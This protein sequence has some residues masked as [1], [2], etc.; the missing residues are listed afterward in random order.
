MEVAGLVADVDFES[1][2]FRWMGAFRFDVQVSKLFLW[3]I[4]FATKYID[5]V[6]SY[7]FINVKLPYYGYNDLNSSEHLYL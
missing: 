2:K 4:T 3:Q 6:C 7:S 5:V 1:E